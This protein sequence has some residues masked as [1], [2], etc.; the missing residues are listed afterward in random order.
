MGSP[1]PTLLSPFALISVRPERSEAESKDALLPPVPLV[2]RFPK[3]TTTT[4]L[5]LFLWI[6][7]IAAAPAPASAQHHHHQASPYAHTRSSDVPTLTPDEVR[8]L[9]NGEGMGLA[10]PAE[11]NRFP[12]PKHLLELASELD[13]HPAQ[14]RRIEAIHEKMRAHAVAKGEEI[15]MAERRLA[16]LFASAAVGE[17]PS[18]ADVKRIA[19]HLGVMRGQLQ[20]IHLLAHMESARELTVEQSEE[21]DRLRGYR[22]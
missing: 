1:T 2:R 10:R 19:E 15:L 11:L 14:V 20:A 16:N 8:E 18:V 17:R 6:S 3:T 12:G 21:Y 13:L 4:V 22:H 9:R 5:G 7:S